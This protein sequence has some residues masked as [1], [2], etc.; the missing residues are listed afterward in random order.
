MKRFKRN[1]L[2]LRFLV[3][4][5]LLITFGVI[6]QFLS[7]HFI[8]K[9]KF[10][11]TIESEMN[12]KKEEL[13]RI[14]Y[15]RA[16]GYLGYSASIAERPDVAEKVKLKD[17]SAL[18]SIFTHLFE[19][20]S[21][22][23]PAVSTIEATDERGIVLIRG[24]NPEKF[25]DDK[26]KIPLFNKVLE[27]KEPEVG[28]EVSPTTL[29]LSIDAVYPIIRGETL[30]GLVKVGSYPTSATF[31]QLKKV[32]G[33]DIGMVYEGKL[34]GSS[35]SG[36]EKV[37]NNIERELKII[38]IGE[39]SYYTKRYP[40]VFGGSQVEGLELILFYNTKEIKA[41]ENFLKLGHIL[42][43]VFLLFLLIGAVFVLAKRIME[44]I[45]RMNESLSKI[46]GLNF[47]ES[48]KVDSTFEEY[49]KSYQVL[50]I[51]QKG[52]ELV[53]R[54]IKNAGAVLFDIVGAE[55]KN[56]EKIS[57]T[58]SA[59]ENLAGSV[60]TLGQEV[61]DLLSDIERGAEEMKLAIS[62]IS[63]NTFEASNRAK[64]LR[65]SAQDMIG[66]VL[67]LEKS[68]DRIREISETI[69]GIAEQTN[70]LALNASIEAARAGEAGRGFAVVA[71]EVKELA[72][73]VSDFIGEIEKIVGELSEVV[74][75]VV[76]KAKKSEEMIDEVEK[77][78]SIIAGAVEEQVAVVGN[79]VENTL[80]TKE[81]SF[82]LVSKVEELNKVAYTLRT[83][84]KDLDVG[85]KI[86]EE[87]TKSFNIL[88]TIAEVTEKPIT[89][90]DLQE[91]GVQ[92]TIKNAMVGHINWKIGF[93]RDAIRGEVPKVE[94][95]HRR[96]LL[97][98]A[99][100]YLKLKVTDPKIARL[101]EEI[102]DPHAKLH[103]LVNKF[104]KINYK[105]REEVYKFLE[106][107]TLPVFE[108]VIKKLE[109]I[110]EACKR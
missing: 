99:L 27:T 39:D 52:L 5:T 23:N 70:L 41:L 86:I 29:K 89:D 1:S 2:R 25:G 95:D 110:I 90:E 82:S 50:N 81:K 8:F 79:I 31:E 44:P 7:S 12:Q 30:L 20:I 45:L 87:V 35:I 62:E 80:Q 15:N 98:R 16:F 26:S 94:R 56:I 101:I 34:L 42:I 93:L 72:K 106:K 64:L 59:V 58:A 75:T 91:M 19:T 43:G 61:S 4:M 40:F 3:F 6:F 22:V 71:N 104:E 13:E 105:D 51:L 10:T 83:L 32:T 107:E 17:R 11:H 68:M 33:I 74:G 47:K 108:E 37:L 84:S 96:C 14:F 66:T 57:P 92:A 97:G 9:Y 38:K 54:G 46:E 48:L 102:E 78:T 109:E 55:K 36:I 21:S 53:F 88:N 67:N 100:P 65:N 76:S 28:F 63:K 85:C 18:Y 49:K 24:H 73:K 103:G 69:R 60:N 77:S